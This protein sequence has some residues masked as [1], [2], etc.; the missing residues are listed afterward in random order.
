MCQPLIPIIQQTS[1]HFNHQ[2]DSK[3][4]VGRSNGHSLWKLSFLFNIVIN[5]GQVAK[6]IKD[7]VHQIHLAFWGKLW[8]WGRSILR[9]EHSINGS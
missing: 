7:Q 4:Y 2:F 6:S 1:T 5:L 8:T 9:L 3:T